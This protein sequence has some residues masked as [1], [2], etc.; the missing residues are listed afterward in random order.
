MVLTPFKAS[1]RRVVYYTSAKL[2]FTA[3]ARSSPFI[4]LMLIGGVVTIVR[5][6][7]SIIPFKI[8][9]YIL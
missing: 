3:E 1:P 9:I 8:G 5:I 7:R 4:N 2:P 6:I